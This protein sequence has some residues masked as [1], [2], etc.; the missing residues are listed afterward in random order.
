MLKIRS[1]CSSFQCVLKK[2]HF[3]C[4]ADLFTADQK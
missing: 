4:I 1:Q 2:T 3:D